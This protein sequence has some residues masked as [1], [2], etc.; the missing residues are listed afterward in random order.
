MAIRTRFTRVLPA[1]VMAA[2]TMIGGAGPAGAGSQKAT[3][4]AAPPAA[5]SVTP[6]T[7]LVDNQTVTI[8]TVSTAD[9]YVICP[10]ARASNPDSC[11]YLNVETA[12][13]STATVKIPARIVVSANDG[14]FSFVD[15]RTTSCTIEAITYPMDAEE[16]L[17]IAS[18]VLAFNPAS[19]LRTPPTLTAT[20][21]T[22]LVDGQRVNVTVNPATEP[23]ALDGTIVLQCIAPINTLDDL[24]LI[25]SK[26]SFENLSDISGPAGGTAV[27]TVAVSAY[28]ATPTGPV[29][30][31]ATT[32]TCVLV[33]FD[34]VFQSSNVPL[35]FDEN[36]PVRPAF[37]RRPIAVP[38]A[39]PSTLTYDLV[40]FT[41][42]DPFTVRW[43]NP[44]GTCLPPV[45]ASG[46]LDANGM[47]SFTVDEYGGFPDTSE[48]DTT[49]E[50][51]C[52]LT[53]T[54]AHGL[55]AT[56]RDQVISVAPME[57]G[58]PFHSKRLPVQVTPN[59]GLHDGDTVTVTASGFEPGATV[60]IIECNGSAVNVGIEACDID[61]STFINGPDITADAQGNV[62]ATYAITRNI[63]TPQ[64]GPL[65][66]ATGNVDPD[67]YLAGIAADPSRANLTD[68]G[69]FSCT[70]VVADVEDYT[71]S[72]GSPIAFEGAIFRRLPW[73]I[74][75]V[76][77]APA[78]PIAAQPKFTG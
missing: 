58:G 51:E 30:C 3:S 56:S 15:C 38:S 68:A 49:C 48:G 78:K 10:T 26:C 32:S 75:P 44:E 12:S 67:A 16:P 8:G 28:I 59:K 24:A 69:Y 20:P 66:C 76:A 70:V 55:T 72:G 29:D 77:A 73:E 34:Q 27:G 5:L 35:T 40:G 17:V 52:A 42:G 25:Y 53:A 31:R 41:P 22:G 62:T 64:D 60:A 33:T 54:D 43:C 7:G 61:T 37:L 2:A 6:S 63:N 4:H 45:I 11:E 46:T 14:T 57:P 9:T 65:D 23:D 36:G 13:M 1:L 39:Q 18:K 50:Q 74:E 71:Q 47:A 19:A 21:Q